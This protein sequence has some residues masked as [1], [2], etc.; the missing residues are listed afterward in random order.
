MEG[1]G[2]IFVHKAHLKIIPFIKKLSLNSWF[3]SV[4]PQLLKSNTF[5]EIKQQQHLQA[6][7]LFQ[8]PWF[9]FEKLFCAVK[10]AET[11][12]FSFW[13]CQSP[14]GF[15]FLF[16]LFSQ[17]G[18]KDFTKSNRRWCIKVEIME[19]QKPEF[20]KHLKCHRRVPMWTKV[21]WRKKTSFEALKG[22]S[23]GCEL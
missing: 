21:L 7:Q 14:K 19:T 15:H 6:P 18:M 5:W 17:K 4:V 1:S 11:Y 16:S 20:V 13:W 12:Y 10:C 3:H 23:L 2:W 8:I 9:I 22:F